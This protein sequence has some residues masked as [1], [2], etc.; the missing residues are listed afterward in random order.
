MSLL[1]WLQPCQAEEITEGQIKS[2]YVLNFAKFTEWPA[3]AVWRDNKITLCA[4]GSNVLGGALMDLDKRRA[5]GRELGVIPHLEADNSLGSC[6]IV[7]IGES[8]RKRVA[9]ILKSIGES[10]TLTISDMDDFA[11]KGGCIGLKYQ[12]SRVVF[13]VNLTSIR[14]TRLRLPSQLLNLASTVFGRQN[15]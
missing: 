14:K 8:E 10:P 3:N 12:G 4:I 15:P 2:A 13:D 5:G 7:F 6:N 9:E 11:E 1:L